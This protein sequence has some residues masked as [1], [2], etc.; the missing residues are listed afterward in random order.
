MKKTQLLTLLLSSSFLVACGGSDSSSSGNGASPKNTSGSTA[1]QLPS[2]IS[3]EN[4]NFTV[5][6]PG[7]K[8]AWLS[9]FG[10]SVGGAMQTGDPAKI[11]QSIFKVISS[12]KIG[13]GI[14]R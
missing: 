7:G 9:G 11:S 3:A 12:V 6:Y 13:G 14:N 5:D 2:S 4:H 8:E 10:A 1:A